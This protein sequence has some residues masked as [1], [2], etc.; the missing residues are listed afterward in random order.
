MS[1]K[2]MNGKQT[3]YLFAMRPTQRKLLTGYRSRDGRWIEV[4]LQ[5]QIRHIADQF[6]FTLADPRR[7]VG[8]P[9]KRSINAEIKRLKTERKI[10]VENY[11]LNVPIEKHLALIDARLKELDQQLMDLEVDE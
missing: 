9:N 10:V 1:D 5:P 4:N 3:E 11:D 8:T 2:L 7:T 6:E